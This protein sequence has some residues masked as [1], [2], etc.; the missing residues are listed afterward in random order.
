M[1]LFLKGI[2]IGIGR[3][4]KANLAS[5]YFNLLPLALRLDK[6]SPGPYTGSG[7]NVFH[8]GL[9]ESC[10]FSNYL[11]IVYRRSVVQR[12]EGYVLVSA[13][14]AHPTLYENLGSRSTFIDQL[15]Y[16]VPFHMLS[17]AGS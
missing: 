15:F 9:I 10:Q 14:G 5:L 11:Y 1:S 13:L 17:L 16:L 6:Y 12:D 8:Q 7:G 2:C 4:V 3:S